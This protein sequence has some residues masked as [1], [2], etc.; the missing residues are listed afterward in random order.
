M[1]R[2]LYISPLKAL[3]NDIHRNLRV[4]LEGINTQAD[5]MEL[6]L[7]EIRVAVR[8]GDTT[9]RERQAMIRKPPHILITTPES[10]Y[11]I[12]T[13]P[14]ARE[15]F[16]TVQTV[17]VDEIHTLAGNKRG[18]HLSLSLE[19]LQH[20]VEATGAAFGFVGNYSTRWIVSRVS[21]AGQVG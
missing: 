6:D 18:V 17:I 12:L 8:S 7:P 1:C 19:R 15:M 13:S 2:L 16:R 11:L 9:Q 5:E 14:K 20:L 21:W 3:N 4:P 10:F